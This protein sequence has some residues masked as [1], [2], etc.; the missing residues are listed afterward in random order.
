MNF[1]HF[2]D[3]EQYESILKATFLIVLSVAGNFLAETLGCQTQTLLNNMY[4]KH[5]LIFF[6]IYFTIDFTQGDTVDNPFM[7][8]GKALIVWILFHLFTHMDI[9]PT[10]LA[11]SLFM[12]LFFISNYRHYIKSNL[13]FLSNSEKKIT[14]Q[15]DKNLELAQTMVFLSTLVVIIIGFGIYYIEK[16]REY[17]KHFSLLKF[18][19]GN[20]TCKHSTPKRAKLFKK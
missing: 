18:I 15:I 5:I 2:I 3:N 12:I 9:Q 7:N 20:P 19:F 1:K 8:I 6:V 13:K 4:A 16:R 10:I 14:L 11:I 17:S